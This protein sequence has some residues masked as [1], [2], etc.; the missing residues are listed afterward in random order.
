MSTIK[1]LLCQWLYKAWFYVFEKPNMICKGWKQ[2]GLL[3]AFD[4][5]FQIQ[6][7]KDNMTV[8]LFPTRPDSHTSSAIEADM[9]NEDVTSNPNDSIEDSM[10]QSLNHVA[11]LCSGASTAT[12]ISKLRM[13]AK[14]ATNRL[15]TK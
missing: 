10:Q 11:T 8:P 7:M 3:R 15:A 14:R 9:R 1:P 5:E 2:A 12:S 6:A 4:K 13:L